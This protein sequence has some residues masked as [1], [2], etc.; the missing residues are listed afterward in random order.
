M[1]EEREKLRKAGNFEE[2]DNV[3]KNIEN[4]GF[5]IVDSPGG[6]RVKKLA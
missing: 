2:A 5:G 4:K 3:R 1:L 6:A